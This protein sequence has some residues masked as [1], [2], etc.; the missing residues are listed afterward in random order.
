M[1]LAEFEK[2]LGLDADP[3]EK[4]WIHH[5]EAYAALLAFALAPEGWL[6]EQTVLW[7]GDNEVATRSITK[8]F[9]TS[10]CLAKIS[11]AVWGLLATKRTR[12]F[13][14]GTRTE[15]QLGDGPSRDYWDEVKKLGC[16]CSYINRS[17]FIPLSDFDL[18]GRAKTPPQYSLI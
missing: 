1:P 7:F 9:S 12:P 13:I 3:Q 14:E 5:A 6:D 18:S 15:L 11:A 10:R 4:A 8:G 17:E 2:I 16:A